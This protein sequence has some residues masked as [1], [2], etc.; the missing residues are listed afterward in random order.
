MVLMVPNP[1]NSTQSGTV[2]QSSGVEGSQTSESGAKQVVQ[3]VK[4]IT[5]EPDGLSAIPRVHVL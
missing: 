2:P 4:E 5:S 3:Q 1:K